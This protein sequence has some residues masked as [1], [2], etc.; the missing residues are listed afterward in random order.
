[1]DTQLLQAFVIAAE[2]QSFSITAE[3]LHVSQSAISKR[4]ALLEQQMSHLLFD[5]VGRKVLL[6]EAGNALLPRAKHILDA[7][8]DAKCYM[9]QQ[10]G[11]ISG[12]L[13]LATSHHIG[14]HRL[15]PILK[16]YRQQYPNVHLQLHFI[17]SEQAESILLHNECDLAITTLPTT[18][19]D[20]SGDL[21][22]HEIWQD[23]MQFVVSP[24]HPLCGQKNIALK[25][26]LAYPAILPDA[27][28]RTTQ[29]IKQLFGNDEKLTI[30]M[31]SNHLDAIK[32]MVAV[33]LGWSV[34]PDSLLD[35]S[36]RALTVADGVIIRQLGCIHHRHRTLSNAAR[37]MLTCMK[38]Q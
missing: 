9:A 24:Q 3:Q 4:I 21:Q 27:T 17:D 23:P 28:T 19:D 31:T 38:E 30:T 15:P 32:M 11:D 33:G 37:A 16:H 18:M 20:G 22:Y 36:V 8:D 34:L 2:E 35:N 26:L 13:R 10:S 25:Q 29:L 5:R 7:I 12:E 6:T 14:I 1:M